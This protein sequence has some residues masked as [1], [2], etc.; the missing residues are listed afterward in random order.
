MFDELSEPFTKLVRT[1]VGSR[2]IDPVVSSFVIT[3]II[4]TIK[5]KKKNNMKNQQMQNKAN[6]QCRVIQEAQTAFLFYVI[7]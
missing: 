1:K 4:V 6:L 5:K 3:I 7:K 2:W